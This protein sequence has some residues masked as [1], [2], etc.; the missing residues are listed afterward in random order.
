[1]DTPTK[2]TYGGNGNRLTRERLEE[3]FE[4]ARQRATEMG[5][6]FLTFVR[7][8]PGTALVIALGAGYLIGRILRR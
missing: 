8:R 5:E 1:M 6:A 3:E 2:P 7:E 4:H